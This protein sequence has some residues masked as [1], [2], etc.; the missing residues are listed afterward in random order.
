MLCVPLSGDPVFSGF[1]GQTY[2]VHGIAGEVFNLV[3]TQHLQLNA[4]FV[5]LDEGQSITSAQ[6]AELR[7]ASPA[8][9]YPTTAAWSHPGTYLGA[10][11]LQVESHGLVVHAGRYAEG[12]QS[13]TF[14]GL[15]ITADHWRFAPHAVGPISLRFLAPG[16]LAVTTAELSFHL[17]NADG[18]LNV[19]NAQL[20][21]VEPEDIDGVLG[22]SADAKRSTPLPRGLSAAPVTSPSS[23]SP[24]PLIVGSVVRCAVRYFP[25]FDATRRASVAE[26]REFQKR[27]VYDYLVSKQQ[28]LSTE[29]V[30]NKFRWGTLTTER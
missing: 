9:R 26:K 3:T 24:T 12:F 8:S 11:G 21:T 14:D 27:M 10:V 17:V 19:E 15:A 29:F 20:G 1:H 4:L 13:V 18:F 22:Q 7:T 5:F 25:G 2:Q 23:P 16:R 28:L 6:M 30:A